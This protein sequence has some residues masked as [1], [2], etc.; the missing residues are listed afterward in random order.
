MP[1]ADLLRDLMVA[2]NH[3]ALHARELRKLAV[4][5][6]CG[7]QGAIP[8]VLDSGLLLGPRSAERRRKM[9]V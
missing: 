6:P 4:A 1:G 7:F 8:P 5:A 9:T 3:L 2:E